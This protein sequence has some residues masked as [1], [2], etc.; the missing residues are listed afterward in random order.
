[1]VMSPSEALASPIVRSYAL[2]LLVFLV[3]AGLA[4]AVVQ[5]GLKKS[6][7]KVWVIYR[8]WLVMAPL[9]LGVIVAGRGATIAFFTVAAVLGFKELARATGLY[10]DW[11]LTGSVYA[12]IAATGV[13]TWVADPNFADGSRPGRSGCF[14]CLPV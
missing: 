11:W 1:M 13:T 14:T 8:S 7:A 4:L 2:L 9:T 6:A 5:F 10:H 12:A 3:G